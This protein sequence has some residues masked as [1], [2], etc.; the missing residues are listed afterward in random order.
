[1]SDTLTAQEI[2]DI[3]MRY[4]LSQRAF[5]RVL[6]IGEASVVRYENGVAPTR[7]NA[8]L[9]RAA[10]LPQFMLDCLQR[11]GELLTP[12]QRQK[13]EAV[14]YAEVS[15]NEKGEVMDM[16]EIY[17]ITL[18]QEV[19]NEKA[20]NML[21]E[22]LRMR[23]EAEAVGDTARALV[24]EDAAKQIARAKGCI[25][26]AETNTEV[27]EIRGRIDGFIGLVKALESRAA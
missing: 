15:L 1:M 18:Q 17:D 10:R 23:R 8:N 25:L 12:E 20:A 13:A 19:L 7:A 5:A 9:I 24:Y 14:I 26:G 21:G 2:R 6:G 4:G 27:A 16:N 3:R 11:D 22:L